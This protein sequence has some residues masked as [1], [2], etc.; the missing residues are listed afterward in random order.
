V[1]IKQEGFLIMNDTNKSVYRVCE[2]QKML[3]I[4]LRQTYNLVNGAYFPI[5]KIG[6]TILIP[7]SHFDDWLNGCG[8][9]ESS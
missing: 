9:T 7:K 4:G 6:R 2:I 3:G 8:G 1:L 5:K